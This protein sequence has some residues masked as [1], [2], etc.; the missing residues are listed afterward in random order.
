MG[1]GR[2]IYEMIDKANEKNHQIPIPKFKFHQNF[3][4]KSQQFEQKKII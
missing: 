4:T 2:I 1:D 3:E